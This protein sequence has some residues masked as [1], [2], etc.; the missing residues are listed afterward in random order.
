M[1]VKAITTA[2]NGSD[3][4]SKTSTSPPSSNNSGD[5]VS[6]VASNSL[7]FTQNSSSASFTKN[8]NEI[9]FKKV[10]QFDNSI[11]GKKFNTWGARVQLKKTNPV[12]EYQWADA[13]KTQNTTK[14]ILHYASYPVIKPFQWLLQGSQW[15]KEHGDSAV[16]NAFR[17]RW[18]FENNLEYVGLT[19]EE[20]PKVH[21]VLQELWEEYKKSDKLKYKDNKGELK[22]YTIK[23]VVSMY[24]KVP[25]GDD[26]KPSLK[27]RF[28][29][30]VVVKEKDKDGNY[31]KDAI[32]KIKTKK[33]DVV[34]G[35]F[36]DN[37]PNDEDKDLLVYLAESVDF[38]SFPKRQAYSR[39]DFE[40]LIRN[41]GISFDPDPDKKVESTT[42]TPPTKQKT[43]ND[44]WLHA[45]IAGLMHD[46]RIM[47]ALT[48]YQ[49]SGF[50]ENNPLTAKIEADKK[51]F[52]PEDSTSFETSKRKAFDDHKAKT[53]ALIECLLICLS[54][55]STDEKVAETING[56]SADIRTQLFGK[57]HLKTQEDALII[58]EAMIAFLD[59]LGL[60]SSVNI[61]KKQT[62]QE[63]SIFNIIRSWLPGAQ[64]PFERPMDAPDKS[65]EL[66]LPSQKDGVQ[67]PELIE[68]FFYTICNENQT[69]R[70][71]PEESDK[72]WNVSAVK[73]EFAREPEG[74]VSFHIKRFNAD[75]TK[76]DSPLNAVPLELAYQDKKF[77]P[78][79]GG[80]YKLK[81][82]IIHKGGT[83]SG[84]YYTLY[85][86][87]NDWFI[88]DTGIKR[89]IETLAGNSK[90]VDQLVADHLEQ[91]VYLHYQKDLV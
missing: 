7:A 91:A 70:N 84:H 75:R 67:A 18:G 40:K 44:C 19:E 1:S 59:D 51:T 77:I 57:G 46:Q 73:R 11:D 48:K 88:Y 33:I 17:R 65:I 78:Q 55:T 68:S 79:I 74:G 62:L 60:L 6:N 3:P 21:K 13:S 2:P 28:T 90:T 81:Y 71:T 86:D 76:N 5:A 63:R 35:S 14:R 27:G 52:N 85:K 50:D 45:G 66:D 29:Y 12:H 20:A 41:G 22:N 9:T 54:P 8:A 56:H 36:S 37:D 24:I 49:A 82:A 69:F 10:D 26:G 89:I 58:H 31:I 25:L 64:K 53:K 34:V 39:K 42:S 43:A 30:V 15:A 83:E 38:P 61:K 47:D 16:R 87:G 4:L 32:G 72:T 80:A 23:D